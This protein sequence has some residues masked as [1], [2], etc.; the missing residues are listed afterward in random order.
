MGPA[1][2]REAGHLSAHHGDFVAHWLWLLALEESGLTERRSEIWRL[3]GV[4]T[5][6][7]GIR[8]V[9]ASP[10]VHL[11]WWGCAARP[12]RSAMHSAGEASRSG[13]TGRH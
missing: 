13:N 1:F 8:D 5:S 3:H 11:A 2:D 4:L 10:L 12:D 6:R 7:D 9:F